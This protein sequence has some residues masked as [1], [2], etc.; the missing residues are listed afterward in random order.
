MVKPRTFLIALACAAVVAIGA[1]ALFWDAI[2]GTLYRDRDGNAHGSGVKTYPYRSGAIQLREEYF[3]GKLVRSEW[4]KPDGTSIH[5]TEWQNEAGE[6][7]YLRE[8]GTIR[9]RQTYTNGLAHGQTIYYAEDG[10]VLGEAEFHEGVRVSGY[11]PK[12]EPESK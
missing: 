6:G 4:F 5:V 11:D 1:V 7:I 10:S 8:D 12:A 2:P 9:I 3:R